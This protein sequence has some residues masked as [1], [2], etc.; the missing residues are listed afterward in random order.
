MLSPPA[1][2]HDPDHNAQQKIGYIQA[3]HVSFNKKSLS[4]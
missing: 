3:D 4:S 1:P 2:K